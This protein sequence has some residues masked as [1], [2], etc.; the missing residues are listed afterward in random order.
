MKTRVTQPVKATK[1]VM[2]TARLEPTLDR[3]FNYLKGKSDKADFFRALLI[4]ELK[5]KN[6]PEAK[7]LLSE[8]IR[9]TSPLGYF[10]STD[11]MTLPFTR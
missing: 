5:M 3:A 7:A 1:D 6:T 11:D 4:R 9:E 10:A 2:F 8:F